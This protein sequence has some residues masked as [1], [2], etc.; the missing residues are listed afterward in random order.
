MKIIIFDLDDTLYDRTGQ[1]KDNFSKQDFLEIKPF[2]GTKTILNYPG[3]K[4]ILVST[5][6]HGAE[7]QKSKLKILEILHL[8]DELIFCQNDQEKLNVFKQI[9]KNHS[10]I[11]AKDILV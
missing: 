10:N 7:F 5:A 3:Y 2:P 8:F 9:L 11:T 1:L 6:K 4:K